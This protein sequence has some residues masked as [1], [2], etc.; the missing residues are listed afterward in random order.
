MAIAEATWVLASVYA[1]EAEKDIATAVFGAVCA[2]S[3]CRLGPEGDLGPDNPARAKVAHVRSRGQLS[4]NPR[5]A[6]RVRHLRFRRDVSG[7]SPPNASEPEPFI[8]L[9][10]RSHW[11]ARRSAARRPEAVAGKDAASTSW[12]RTK[13]RTFSEAQRHRAPTTVRAKS[14]R[15]SERR[16]PGRRH[17]VGEAR[18]RP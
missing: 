15:T 10:D 9:P 7:L 16:R 17:E 14:S 13:Q 5:S 2:L 12:R 1:R 4:A 6:D 3:P 8:D 18:D 11:R